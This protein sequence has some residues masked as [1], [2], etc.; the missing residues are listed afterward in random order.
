MDSNLDRSYDNWMDAFPEK[1]SYKLSWLCSQNPTFGYN[2][3]R[4]WIWFRMRFFSTNCSIR[5]VMSACFL[6]IK[7]KNQRDTKIKLRLCYHCALSLP[8]ICM[9]STW[10]WSLIGLLLVCLQ[11]TRDDPPM[12]RGLRI[13]LG[14]YSPKLFLSWQDLYSSSCFCQFWTFIKSVKCLWCCYRLFQM[15]SVCQ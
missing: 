10:S 15:T 4:N 5:N 11:S 9:I 14:N 13:D 1:V 12:L 2:V 7:V 3:Q 8:D 6:S